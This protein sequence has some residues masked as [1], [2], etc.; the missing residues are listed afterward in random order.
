L[1]TKQVDYKYENA[2]YTPVRQLDMEYETNTASAKAFKSGEHLPGMFSPDYMNGNSAEQLMAITFYEYRMGFAKLKR[3]V[4]TIFE[5]GQTFKQEKTYSYNYG[6]PG[7]PTE[8]FNTD[9]RFLQL[10]SQKTS[11]GSFATHYIYA[12][13]YGDYFPYNEMKSRHILS[14]VIEKIGKEV[15]PGVFPGDEVEYVVNGS[16]TTYSLFNNTFQPTIKYSL[17]PSRPIH[18]FSFSTTHPT[19]EADLRYYTP[20]TFHTLYTA[21]GLPREV[22]QTT[23]LT[24]LADDEVSSYIYDNGNSLLIAKVTNGMA[25]QS[26]FTDFENGINEGGWNF[27]DWLPNFST[28]AKTGDFSFSGELNSALLPAGTYTVSLWASG[29]GLVSVQGESKIVAVDWRRYEW[30]VTLPSQGSIN[31]VTNG[32]LIDGLRLHA[33]NA[34]MTTFTHQALIGVTSMTDEN[35]QTTYY[36]YDGLNRLETVRDSDKNIVRHYDYKYRQ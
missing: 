12:F 11:T 32:H 35:H 20:V 33:K 28:F 3:S 23:D 2:Q 29:T 15:S 22:R 10:E 19:G 21:K 25:D 17:S 16:F 18:D 5:K 13:N 14:P 34:R 36:E 31:V 24:T 27:S 1:L 30:T 26:A 7:G 4:E 8:K 9:G 6:A